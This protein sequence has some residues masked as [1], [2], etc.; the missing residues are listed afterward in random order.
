QPQPFLDARMLALAGVPQGQAGPGGRLGPGEIA[1]GPRPADELQ[2]DVLMLA[3]FLVV[4]D[5]AAQGQ[6][7]GGGALHVR[8]G[9]TEDVVHHSE[10]Y[11]HLGQHHES[12]TQ[13]GATPGLRSFSDA[14]QKRPYAYTI[15][16][17]GLM[18]SQHAAAVKN[19]AAEYTSARSHCPWRARYAT[20]GG[21]T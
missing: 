7:P 9:E 21:L 16:R 8:G 2:V 3:G 10:V 12:S 14:S 1:L 15:T 6:Q 18:N 19:I 4:H 17:R 13:I 20:I 11:S 5:L